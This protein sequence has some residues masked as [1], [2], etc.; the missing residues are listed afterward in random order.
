VPPA[1]AELLT[2]DVS[3]RDWFVPVSAD[4]RMDSMIPE[5][6]KEQLS[7]TARWPVVL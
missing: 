1:K 2:I 6:G 5:H 4:T 7:K 3:S